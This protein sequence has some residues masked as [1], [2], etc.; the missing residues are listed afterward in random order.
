M[1]TQLKFT[2]KIKSLKILIIVSL[3][4][5]CESEEAGNESQISKGSRK[6]FAFSFDLNHEVGTAQYGS[7]TISIE[8]PIDVANNSGLSAKAYFGNLSSLTWYVL[9]ILNESGEDIIIEDNGS[10]TLSFYDLL[11]DFSGSTTVFIE[12]DLV[13]D[14]QNGSGEI[15]NHYLS[16]GATGYVVEPVVQ[17]VASAISRLE[18][19]FTYS[20][21][22]D[23]YSF[24]EEGFMVSIQSQIDEDQ[25][26]DLLHKLTNQLSESYEVSIP[27]YILKD[28]EGKVLYGTFSSPLVLEPN[29]PVEFL[30]SFDQFVG[31][32][33]NLTLVFN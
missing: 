23:N 20:T 13:R 11:G 17:V 10:L 4:I 31:K 30:V 28:R 19:D 33:S 12:G 25:N 5:S 27:Y 14:Y 2:N 1:K 7:D 32:A 21:E 3:L 29:V 6:E 16:S 8:L 22:T 15:V 24:I 26:V 9:E 18:L